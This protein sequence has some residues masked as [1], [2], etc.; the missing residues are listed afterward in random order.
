MC[1]EVF[2]SSIF[3]TQTEH[4]Q[5]LLLDFELNLYKNLAYHLSVLN[6]HFKLGMLRNV[7]T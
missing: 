7:P 3:M 1:P 4:A 5:T 6:Y 2:L